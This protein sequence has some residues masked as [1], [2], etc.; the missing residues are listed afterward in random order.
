VGEQAGALFGATARDD[1]HAA[2]RP[3][4]TPKAVPPGQAGFRPIW[5]PIGLAS[6]NEA[7]KLDA[8][9]AG[10]ASTFETPL[11]SSRRKRGQTLQFETLN[12]REFGSP[13]ESSKLRRPRLAP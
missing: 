1:Q 12:P 13:F 3:Q 8:A 10:C 2:A 7:L 5:L 9:A 4:D 11:R 6:S